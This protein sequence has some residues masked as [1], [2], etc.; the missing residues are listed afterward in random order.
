MDE[1]FQN[2][3]SGDDATYAIDQ[4]L[5]SCAPPNFTDSGGDFD[6]NALIKSVGRETIRVLLVDA[7][8]KLAV[9]NETKTSIDYD[10][11]L[12][13]LGEIIEIDANLDETIAILAAKN[14]SFKMLNALIQKKFDV[15]TYDNWGRTPLMYAA[16]VDPRAV[17]ED[18]LRVVSDLIEVSDVNQ[19][20]TL[21]K[22]ALIHAIQNHSWKVM[23]RIL[24]AEGIDLE[25]MDTTNKNA[26]WY[27]V[28][29]SKLSRTQADT[30]KAFSDKMNFDLANQRCMGMTP[31]MHAIIVRNHYAFQKLIDMEAEINAVSE[32]K[33]RYTALIMLL[34][35]SIYGRNWYIQL[36]TLVH[37]SDLS[38]NDAN[39]QTALVHAL[40]SKHF[41]E[42]DKAASGEKDKYRN[43]LNIS[44]S[45]GRTALMHAVFVN[46]QDASRK[47]LSLFTQSEEKRRFVHKHD[48]RS[49]MT[50]LMFALQADLHECAHILIDAG[51]DVDIQNYKNSTALMMALSRKEPNEDVIKRLVENASDVDLEDSEGRSAMW[52]ALNTDNA[53]AVRLLWEK[54]A[55]LPGTME[56][57]DLFKAL[58]S[59]MDDEEGGGIGDGKN[60]LMRYAEEGDLNK[61]RLFVDQVNEKPSSEDTALTVAVEKNKPKIVKLLL[62]NGAS[63][64]TRNAAKAIAIEKKM[65]NVVWEFYDAMPIKRAFYAGGKVRYSFTSDDNEAVLLKRDLNKEQYEDQ[66][67]R[68]PWRPHAIYLPGTKLSVDETDVAYVVEC[69]VDETNLD[70]EYTLEYQGQRSKYRFENHKASVIKISPNSN[71]VP[72]GRVLFDNA[73]FKDKSGVPLYATFLRGKEAYPIMGGYLRSNRFPSAANWTSVQGTMA[74]LQASP[75]QIMMAL[76][77]FRTGDTRI[78]SIH[79]TQKLWTNHL[80][81]STY[82]NPKEG[83]CLPKEYTKTVGSVRGTNLK[84]TFDL[85]DAIRRIYAD[86]EKTGSTDQKRLW[87][88]QTQKDTSLCFGLWYKMTPP[89]SLWSLCVTGAK[90]R[91]IFNVSSDWRDQ[92]QALI[93]LLDKTILDAS[94]NEFFPI[95]LK[96]YVEERDRNKDFLLEH[97]SKFN[98][99]THEKGNEYQRRCVLCHKLHYV[100]IKEAERQKSVLCAWCDKFQVEEK[101]LV[102]GVN[103]EKLTNEGWMCPF[104]KDVLSRQEICD[105]NEGHSDEQ[106][107]GH[108]YDELQTIKDNRGKPA[109]DHWK[110]ACDPKVYWYCVN[111]YNS[112]PPKRTANLYALHPND[113]PECG[114]GRTEMITINKSA[115]MAHPGVFR[116]CRGD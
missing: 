110:D 93:N 25:P 28:K 33:N 29:E 114:K 43:L 47:F 96:V 13:A 5:I 106:G 102:V 116:T 72:K 31:L 53:T 23:N 49:G 109:D 90:R 11:V 6:I 41:Y 58:S 104:S 111:C 65:Y 80:L 48:H 98:F 38:V 32:D 75:E 36:Q 30:F 57:N 115:K 3:V 9:L 89:E 66:P 55:T 95:Q 51:A 50:A 82:Q 26:L 71:F 83:G 17:N 18:S 94:G 100:P 37:K 45:K 63:S 84:A 69:V 16:L 61:C 56:L 40:K 76:M 52:Y 8:K 7:L 34:R 86:I 2:L 113:C 70:T 42:F 92:S 81:K 22:T 21:G 1:F 107:Y 87:V 59:V 97:A 24:Q 39:G 77:A 112:Y 78:G 10:G 20:D 68:M 14:G 105:V 64:E 67:H 74:T 85:H 79:L 35:G 60:R 91:C 101:D 73:G 19:Q 62:A 4:L 88:L 99:V 108:G 44:D 12:D 27:V 46:N 54:E 15:K 103:V